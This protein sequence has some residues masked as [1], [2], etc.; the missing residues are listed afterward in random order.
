M[1]SHPKWGVA[2]QTLLNGCEFFRETNQRIDLLEQL[3]R[4]LGDYLYPA[5]I[6][7]LCVVDSSG[8]MQQKSLLV[9]TLVAALQR[10]R[11][12]TGRLNAWGI[13]Y[14][15]A[16]ASA[17]RNIGPIEYLFMWYAQPS[18]R[19]YLPQFEFKNAATRLMSLF[20]SSPIA[21]KAYCEKMISDI[22]DPLGGALSNKLQLSI[23]KMLESWAQG[24]GIEESV[25][26]FLDEQMKVD[27]DFVISPGLFSSSF[28]SYK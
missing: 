12:P 17:V 21:K 4:A 6:Q 14:P 10:G 13:A 16:D 15:G 7:I 28:L 5:F 25:D 22:H 9:E 3:C 18:G 1:K 23:S 24:N 26:I 11:M 8:N 2:A 19:E 20:E 27:G